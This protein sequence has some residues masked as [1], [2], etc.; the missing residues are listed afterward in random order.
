MQDYFKHKSRRQGENTQQFMNIHYLRLS[1]FT[2]WPQDAAVGSVLLAKDGFF[3]TGRADRVKCFSCDVIIGGWQHGD[4]PLEKHRRARA[5]CAFVNNENHG[6]VP[7]REVLAEID[8][9]RES[10]A[11]QDTVNALL[12]RQNTAH[13]NTSPA[14]IS[15]PTTRVDSP[16][17]ASDLSISSPSDT[18]TTTYPYHIKRRPSSGTQRNN[19]ERRTASHQPTRI[20]LVEEASDSTVD[21]SSLLFEANRFD[22]FVDW[23]SNNPIDPAELSAAGFYYTRISDRVQCVFCYGVLRNWEAGDL[24]F[25]EHQRYFPNCPFVLGNATENVTITD[26]SQRTTG[27]AA[28]RPKHSEY[29]LLV[30]RLESFSM[31]PTQIQQTPALL[32]EAGFYYTGWYKIRSLCVKRVS[33]CV[34]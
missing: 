33:M 34:Y 29:I 31:W 24:A 5:N 22:T 6:N 3:Y 12:C 27:E 18:N 17:R 30:D 8:T 16:G 15:V 26:R 9:S 28:T 20:N 2:N 7:M 25:N 1:T 4:S 11:F 32:A 13:T 19:P 21:W 10:A 23:P 14:P